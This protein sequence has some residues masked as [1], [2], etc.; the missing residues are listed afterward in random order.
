M[1][2]TVAVAPRTSVSTRLARA[3]SGPQRIKELGQPRKQE[4]QSNE[5]DSGFA[6]RQWGKDR[7]YP[8]H[9]DGPAEPGHAVNPRNDV[10]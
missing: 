8:E 4:K 3:L 10:W 2:A 9:D 7:Q 6:R 1:A 5:N